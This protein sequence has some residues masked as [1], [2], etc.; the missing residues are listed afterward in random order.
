MIVK[1][2]VMWLKNPIN[3]PGWKEA[4][5]ELVIRESEKQNSLLVFSVPEKHE[6]EIIENI[7]DLIEGYGR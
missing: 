7:Q 5:E 2:F 4:L 1:S 6:K 3:T